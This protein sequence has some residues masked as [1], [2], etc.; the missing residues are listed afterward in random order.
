MPRHDRQLVLSSLFI[1]IGLSGACI[2]P[3]Y[4]KITVLC[5]AESP[6]CP[7]G[8]SPHM[9]KPPQPSATGPQFAAASMQVRGRH[10]APVDRAARVADRGQSDDPHGSAGPPEGGRDGR[11]PVLLRQPGQRLS[12][13]RLPHGIA[14]PRLSPLTSS[15]MDLLKFGLVSDT[16]APMALRDVAD[17]TLR[18]R[19]LSVP[20]V[21]RITVYGGEV[22]QVQV[23]VDPARLEAADVAFSDVVDAAGAAVAARGG[24]ALDLASQRVPVVVPAVVASADDLAQAV[25]A[26]RNGVPLTLADVAD[27]GDGAAD[28]IGDALIQGRPGVL[29]TILC[30][31][32]DADLLT[33]LLLTES[34]AFGVRR[35]T[36]ERRKLQRE[37]VEV[38]IEYGTIAVKL[39]RLNGTVVQA[40]PEYESCRSI[41][42]QAGIPVRRVYEEALAAAQA[43]YRR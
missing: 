17:R 42:A 31:S 12:K 14:T 21:A 35:R 40:A 15:T 28:R 33:E 29:V 6:D 13:R 25:V 10:A 1:A 20:G 8:Q 36:V 9:S 23:R 7:A 16:V 39:G 3:D 18:P 32:D 11:E 4:S 38:R 19:L 2:G 22:R 24:G 34:S 41:A 37:I 5:N 27:V 43:L 30:G 26:V